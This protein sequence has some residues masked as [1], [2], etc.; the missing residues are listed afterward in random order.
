MNKLHTRDRRTMKKPRIES[1]QLDRIFQKWLDH[2]N[3][4]Q[5][6]VWH[7]HVDHVNLRYGA[8]K[9]FDLYVW[10]CGGRLGKEYGHRYA[11]FFDDV[12]LTM[13][14]LRHA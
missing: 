12:N 13:F 14:V 8:G 10:E 1:E 6:S 11:E 2:Y 4:G 7:D 3:N 5:S 9:S